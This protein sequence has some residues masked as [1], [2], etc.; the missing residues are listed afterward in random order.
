MTS[1][2]QTAINPGPSLDEQ[3][4]RRLRRSEFPWTDGSIYLN[5]ASTGPLPE[6]TRRVLDDLTLRR[7]TP[8]L[9]D[10]VELRNL[11]AD[12]RT[13]AAKQPT[14][15]TESTWLTK[16]CLWLLVIAWSSRLVSSPPTCIPGFI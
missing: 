3:A 16:R 13:A 11:L 10:E 15:A 8:Q 1:S 5:N 2:R 4:V 9:I 6:R 12:T 14:R 7:M